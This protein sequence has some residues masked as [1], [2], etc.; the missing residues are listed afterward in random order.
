MTS[1]SENIRLN[2]IESERIQARID[3]IALEMTKARA[4]GET[5][6]IELIRRH[7]FLSEELAELDR[8]ILSLSEY[9]ELTGVGD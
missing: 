3:E 4:K 1:I 5:P 6:T 9:V 8:A 2:M 7:L